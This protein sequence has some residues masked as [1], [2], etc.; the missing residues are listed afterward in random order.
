MNGSLHIDGLD[1][2]SVSYATLSQLTEDEIWGMIAPAAEMLKT[3][4]QESIRRLFTQRS[5]SLAE[6]IEILRKSARSGEVFA[7]VGPNQG[8]HPKSSQGKRKSRRGGGGGGSYGGTNA[9][10][11]WILE[12][13]SSRIRGRHW[14][15]AACDEAETMA[16]KKAAA[17]RLARLFGNENN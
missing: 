5:G 7:R 8:K 4:M 15:E 10:V 3:K 13:G 16:R 17:D 12:Y 9:E 6:S 14:M 2:L 1:R 11:G